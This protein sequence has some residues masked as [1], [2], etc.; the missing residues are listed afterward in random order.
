M[1]LFNKPKRNIRRRPFDDEDEDNENRM[2][3]EDAQP[4]K[5]KTKKDKPKQTRL[6]FGE[7]LEQGDDGEVFIVKKSSRSK[8]LMKQLDHE[9]RKKKGEEKMQVDTEQANK[10]IKQEKDLE[11]K[12]DDLVVKIKNTGPL[13]LNGRAALAAGKD[14]YTSGEEEDEP[15][16]HKFRKN[17]DKAET[18][19]ILLE[20]TDD[21]GKSRLIREEDHDRS[22]DDDSQD[23][24]DMTVNTEAR[25]KEKRREAFLASQVPLKFSDNESEHENEE[26]EWEAQQIRKGVTGAQYIMRFRIKKIYIKQCVKY[27]KYF[28]MQIA[29]AQQDSM[30]QQQYT[31]GMNVNQI[32]GS[33]VPLEMVLM[34]APPPPPSIQPPDPTKI[35]PVT[36]Q[37]VVNRMRTRLDNLKEV[38]RRHQQDQERLEGELQQTIKE[39]DESEVRTPHYAQRFR[40]YQELRGYVTDLVE[41]LDEKLPLVI[42]LE[43]RWLD[44]YGE[45]SVELMER[46]RQDTRDQAEE[47][48]TTARGQAIRRGP[49]V[50]I[51][52]R[53]ATEREGRR[54]R[55]RRAR[56]LA[57]N[58]PKHID[59]MSSDD[60]VT[61]QQNLV[62]K[63]AKDEIDNNCK[64]IFSDVMEEYCTVRGILSKFESWR[65]TDMD[66]YTEAYVS[67]C[68]PK[69]ISPIIRL[70]LLTWNPIMESADLER[71]KWYNT[72]LLYA[73]D[74]KETEESL[75]RDPDV[76]LIPSTIEK[77][78]IPKLTS[79]I[80]KIWD[81]MSTSQTLRL[82][83]TIN[84]LIK[85]YPN[86]N[87]SSKQLE[88]LFNAILDK[89]K[90]AIENDVFIPI[91]PKQVWDTKHQFFQRQFAMAVKL[92]RNL[93]SWQGILGDI[94]L[95]N[96]A[97]G[98]LLNRYLL[99]GLRVSCPTDALFKANMLQSLKTNMH[100]GNV[101]KVIENID[102]YDDAVELLKPF[103]LSYNK[104]LIENFSTETEP[105]WTTNIKRSIAGILQLDLFNLE[106]EIAFH[107]SETNH[108]GKC[109]IDYIVS[110]ED[111]SRLIRKS[112][113]PRMC[114]G[115]P[116]RYW[117]NVPKVQC[118]DDDQNPILKSSERVYQLKTDG[119]VHN[120]ISVNASG[121]IYVQ[122]FQS[123]GEAHYHFVR[124]TIEL[125]SVK[126]IANKIITNNLRTTVL[127]HEL[128]EID[129]TQGRGTPDKNFVFK[130]ISHLLDRLSH[131][132]ENPG[133]D[134]EIHNLHNT[135]ISVLL[136]YLGM[137]DRVDLGK[138]YTRI[139]GTSYKE[140]TIR[141]MFLEALP[142]VGSR[143]SALFILDLVQGNEVSDMSAIQLLM[144]LPFHIKK[145]DVQLLVSL[146]P[147]L[148]LPSKICAEVQNTAILTYGTLIY[149]TCLVHCPYEML[150]DYVRLYLDKFTETTL[151][152]QKMIWLEGL[153]NIQLG[154]VV[155]FLE[156]IATGNNAESRHFR[157]L[158][159]WAS[160][161]T[162]PL[163]PD[164]IYPVYW[165][166]LL[167]RTEHLEMR[168]AALT[169]LIVSS[170]TPN[171]L[172]SLYW[173]MQN[174]PNQHL[175]NYFYTMLK[176]M[177]RT[178]YPCYRRI[179]KIAAQFS[180]V[181]RVPNNEYMITGNYL[182]D[183][184]DSLRRFGAMLHG[185]IIANP[186]TNIP[187]VIYVT[188]NNY[189]SG[190]HLNH[191]SL[192]I[193]AEGIFHSLA[194]SFDNPTNIKDI[195]KEF[196]LDERMK[197]PMH[198]EIITRIQE[199][200]V[201]CVHWNETNIV[202]GLKYLSSLSDN[203][204]QTYYNM[205]FHV[206]QQRINVPLA[207]ES[208]Q[209]TD[210]GTNVRLA[211]TGTSLFSMRG[212]FTRDFPGR[213]NH[214]ILRTSVHGI[215]T[216]E[217]YNPLVDLWHSAERVQSLHGY[218]PINVTL[219][220]DERPFISYDTLEE[221][222]KT[223][224]TVHART[225]TNIRGANVRSKL[226]RVCRSCSVSHTV[227]KSPS[228][229]LQTV[230]ILNVGL[231][232]LGGRLQVKIFDCE[233]M[234]SY[235]TLINDIWSF[236]RSN[237]QTWPS[238]KF[239]LIG[240]HFLDYFTFVPPKGSCGLA[241]YIEALKFGPS[242]TKLEY[243]KSEN[244]H[245][246]SLTHHDLQSSQVL[247]QW[248]LAGLYEATSWLSDVI[249]FK[250]T[251]IVPNERVLKFCV[252]AER[253]MP[254]Q[255]EILSNEPSESYR[256][257]LNFI[258]GL[259]DTVKGKCSGSSLSINLIGEIS[260]K[261][262]E[263]SKRASWPYG[264]CKNESE[265][266]RIVPY[267]NSCYE[268]SKEMSTLRKYKILA[269]HENLPESLS[270]LVWKLYALYDLIGGNSSIARKSDQL[271]ITAIFPKD[272]NVGELQLNGDKVAIEYNSHFIDLF[273]TRMRI[274]KYME[275]PLFRMFSS[276]CIITLDSIK[277]AYNTVYSFAKNSEVILLGQCYD[278]NPRFVLTAANG[279]YG[280]NVN[281]TDESGT[282][283]IMA[284][285]DR[286]IL[287]N[288]TSSIQLQSDY[289]FH[290]LGTKKI[291]MGDK[292][293]DIL[294]PNLFLYMRWTQQQVLIFFSNHV[295]EFSCGICTLDHPNIDRLYE[296]L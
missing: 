143:E 247:H 9:R 69:I 221:H 296:K 7:E 254:W 70:Q 90:A 117:S 4:V 275:I 61:E 129:L 159:A 73:L 213:N 140:E 267:T 283:R 151:Y 262:L 17:T 239:V 168:V 36:P 197:G 94:Q 141:N 100:N 286:G 203:I 15:C 264:E 235:E 45:R 110:P 272:S 107:S 33:G 237:Y 178:T 54:A 23:R 266:K 215:E 279:V 165:P 78:V 91:F 245:I 8:K 97:L 236:H 240:L 135:T 67:L 16:S 29:A 224:I 32:I 125:A 71:T 185:I 86:L 6:S 196:K 142:Q 192:Y 212:N 268:V 98:S 217:N 271:A 287:Y 24:L 291:K 12:T 295:L 111:D 280:I 11:I 126:D 10:S 148:A 293:I 166:I 76:R 263:E 133:L 37:E 101:K 99:A 81:P 22:D 276:A 119:F 136:Y 128:P 115:H 174:E 191:V 228:S 52:V 248:N 57:S 116:S 68:L 122:P 21:K 27:L 118:T 150:D 187:E 195:L 49:E 146:Q 103:R 88:T 201:L 158:A 31:M 19:K 164:V 243:I 47:I 214:I 38:H 149:K 244:R 41:C 194:T 79:I 277:S 105:V 87:D 48:T 65:E 14:D 223:G 2:E 182:I 281:L 77:I 39:L 75:K 200:T 92:L 89:I 123:M 261:Q 292:A 83:G 51:H 181:L 139:S 96:L 84:R 204:Y 177:E 255:W 233:S 219:G 234:I 242:Q 184:Q 74:S 190:T 147:L 198:L 153:A 137:L 42:D 175:Y 218:L 179:S 44:L 252:E 180:R 294:L 238:M 152:E 284:D 208:V 188:L 274:H 72:L 285:K 18:V 46:R 25:D 211:M 55:R 253:H 26:E 66:A 171:R 13:I 80:E 162:A 210:F 173:Y 220:L 259:S 124:Q 157:V 34:P 131:R 108:Y 278:E 3:V 183:Y 95:K 209:V 225:L 170:P 160:I 169:L 232:E 113:D 290:K 257:K 82:V 59:G 216:I 93:L 121:G 186:S 50:E 134:T 258:W 30:L 229:D 161:P 102:I 172:I 282:T 269:Q 273:L 63:Q 176:S 241:A 270:K 189:A 138:A 60:E 132:L 167:N 64:D 120:I 5:V 106:K 53:R 230:N 226:N 56:E 156:P 130:S 202:E 206:N 155:E 154:K 114:I 193:K 145:P 251:K 163:R 127:Q 246:L 112:F 1:S 288:A 222:L 144:R 199:K 231:P 205:E 207:I 265:G 20:S 256:I 289:A 58:I 28:Y 109:D 43:Q 40:Y 62:F 35:V 227:V 85:E 104:G 250:A 249:K 260:S